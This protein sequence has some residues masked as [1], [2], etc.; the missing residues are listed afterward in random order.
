MGPE[1]VSAEEGSPAL[2]PGFF[3]GLLDAFPAVVMVLD[4]EGTIRYA[5]GQLRQLGDRTQAQLVGAKV[6]DF[7][8]TQAE[9]SLVEELVNVAASRPGGDVVGPAPVPLVDTDGTTRLTE[10]WAANRSS[11]AELGGLVVMLSPE[12]AYDHFDQVLVSIVRDTSLEETFSAL[13]EALRHPPFGG[14][15]YFLTA[16]TDDRAFRRSP[17]G[18]NVPGPPLAGPWDAVWAGATSVEHENLSKLSSELREQAEK[19]GYAS[20]ACF[21]LHPVLE[22]RTDACLVAWS[23]EAGRLTPFARRAIEQAIVIASLAILHRSEQEGLKDAALRDPLTGLGN[24]TSFFGALQRVVDSDEQPAVMY[25]DLDGFK[26]VNDRLGHLAGDAVLRVVARRLASI[27][28]PTDDLAR[29]GDDEFAV[30]CNGAPSAEQMVMI[31]ERVVEQL[32]RPLSVGDRETVYV[33][34]NVGIAIELGVGTPVDTILERA[35]H[36]LEEA[37]ARGRGRWAFASLPE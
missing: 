9:R 18:G 34:A 11:T 17:D 23:P 2:P 6:G 16:A 1:G 35:D 19:A 25:V 3:R 15:C 14:E 30:L 27:M 24:R 10:A 32:S 13:A 29:L 31:A 4:A 5:A 33:G 8:A 37:K 28:R 22:G 20:V 12:S 7:V 26:E 36:A 21:A